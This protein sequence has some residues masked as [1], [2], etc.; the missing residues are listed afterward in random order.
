[1][2]IVNAGKKKNT[3]SNIKWSEHYVPGAAPGTRLTARIEK[4]IKQLQESGRSNL[5]HPCINLHIHR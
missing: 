2:V 5:N 4:Q 1:M 3:K